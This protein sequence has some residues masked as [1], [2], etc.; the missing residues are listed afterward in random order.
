MISRQ[1]GYG[2]QQ[3]DTMNQNNAA[4]QG[5]REA[6]YTEPAGSAFDSEESNDRE[7]QCDICGEVSHCLMCGLCPPCYELNGGTHE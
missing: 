7:E 1:S 4:G 2:G 3:G 5:R 6:T